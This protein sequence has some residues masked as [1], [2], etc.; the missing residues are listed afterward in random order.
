MIPFKN[1]IMMFEKGGASIDVAPLQLSTPQKVNPDIITGDR[2][3]AK[4]PHYSFSL[5]AGYSC[6]YAAECRS[7]TVYTGKRYKTGEGQGKVE[8]GPL[9]KFRC[10]AVSGEGQY[11][12]V[13]GMRNS[14]FEKLTGIDV[15]K[16]FPDAATRNKYGI[17]KGNDDDNEAPVDQLDAVFKGEEAEMGD[18][19]NGV[20]HHIHDTKKIAALILST[21]EINKTKIMN[22]GPKYKGGGVLRVHVSG[23]FYAQ[24]YFDA[25]MIA[26]TDNPDIT[27]YSYTKSLPYWI[28]ARENGTI[29]SNYK[30]VASYGGKKDAL[31][32]ENGFKFAKVC[33]SPDE[34]KYY[35]TLS[36]DAADYPLTGER[37]E[38]GTPLRAFT[39]KDS[40]GNIISRTGLTVCDE[41]DFPA[42]GSDVPFALLLHGTQP[43]DSEAAASISK[44]NKSAKQELLQTRVSYLVIEEGMSELDAHIEV[45]MR[46]FVYN[47]QRDEAINAAFENGTRSSGKKFD[48]ADR[49]KALI[50]AIAKYLCRDKLGMDSDAPVKQRDQ[51]NFLDAA[52]TIFDNR[53]S[54][55]TE[56]AKQFAKKEKT[57]V[58]DSVPEEE[59]DEA[60]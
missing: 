30:L 18:L 46:V 24:S 2:G 5:P 29:P 39:Y 36:A 14:N 45:A 60:A 38:D 25:W 32:G 16:A 22:T 20:A 10:F 4:V 21:I 35:P 26:A 59:Y 51:L 40:D 53:I 41:D 1:F 31:I 37:M 15:D 11:K 6:P 7:R 58:A 33:F 13:R 49:K 23:D 9:C 27:F 12:A 56:W 43:K 19:L 47:N 54:K 48:Y 17:N 55:V 34:A 8:D 57:I 28:K 52:Y 50:N 44:I 3:I 42:Y